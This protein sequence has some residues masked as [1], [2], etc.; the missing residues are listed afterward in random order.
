M[1]GMDAQG[2]LRPGGRRT[3][4]LP[5]GRSRPKT[6]KIAACAE[7][8]N[9]CRAC[10]TIGA[11][12]RRSATGRTT[13]KPAVRNSLIHTISTLPHHLRQSLTWDQGNETSHHHELSFATVLPP[14][15]PPATQLQREHQRLAAAL[16]PEEQRPAHP[17][18][19]LNHRLRK[20]RLTEPVDHLCCRDPSN[21]PTVDCRCLPVALKPGDPL[22]ARVGLSCGLGQVNVVDH[23]YIRAGTIGAPG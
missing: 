10:W 11:V 9:W 1:G 23:P 3:G 2:R 21:P 14:T 17:H 22:G 12:L 18:R 7:L 13:R 16:L 5:P 20:T 15:Q 8:P 4:C 19:P 6:G